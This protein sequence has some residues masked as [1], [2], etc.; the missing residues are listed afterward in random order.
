MKP[1][2]RGTIGIIAL[3]LAAATAQAWEPEV[4]SAMDRARLAEEQ[5][6][7]QAAF[8]AYLDAWADPEHRAEAA[9]RAR[10]IER[11]AR[12]A[13]QDDLSAIEPIQSRLGPGFRTYRSRSFL[14]LSDA[15]DDWTRS[16]ITL[17]ER[18]REQ[19]FREMDRLRIPVHPH[20]HRL[21]CIFFKEH[22]DYIHFA[23]EHDGFEA[24]WAAGYYSLAHNA[25]VI[26]D[27]RTAPNLARVMHELHQQQA[28]ADD[29]T[30][31]AQLAQAKG[32]TDQARILSEAAETLA[33]QIR[34]EHRRIEEQ[35]LSFGVAKVLHEAIHLLAFNTGLQA[36]GTA[37]PLW[38]S[39]GLAASFEAPSTRSQFGFAFPYEPRELELE[40]LALEN[41]LPRLADILT[42]DHNE[43][44][45]AD[46]AR[47]IY[48]VA[49]GL[50]KELHRTHRDELAA[51]LAELADLPPGPRHP[52][53]HV[54]QFERHFGPIEQ[55]ERTLTRRWVFAAREREA[56]RDKELRTAGQ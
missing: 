55:L 2:A 3:A 12:T 15:S 30:G 13:S 48:A 54:V 28:R 32:R 25:I 10:A 7:Q 4:L 8:L 22:A 27:D 11:L 21:I 47:P 14:V 45:D 19:Y 38:V 49:Y 56:K 24:G 26:H 44:L 6:Q 18:A 42:L 36:R 46:S 40:H 16:R 34:Q 43:H 39:E 17:L 29:L 51:Y 5:G 35:V 1:R 20:R 52:R 41:Q 37:Y 33:D 9:R 50:F 31:R 53:D 23:R